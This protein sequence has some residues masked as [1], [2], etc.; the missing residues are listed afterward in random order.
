M[1]TDRGNDQ[2]TLSREGVLRI[3]RDEVEA[4]KAEQA[5]R[6]RD[7]I[8]EHDLRRVLAQARAASIVVTNG[9]PVPS[10]VPE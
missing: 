3:P 4:L 7:R 9:K 2:T 1:T 8:A 10:D 6:V 5:A